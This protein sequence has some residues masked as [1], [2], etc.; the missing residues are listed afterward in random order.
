MS[1]TAPFALLRN[2]PRT[3]LTSTTDDPHVQQNVQSPPFL[4][5]PLNFKASITLTLAPTHTH[6]ERYAYISFSHSHT[7]THTT[8]SLRWLY[9]STQHLRHILRHER[10]GTY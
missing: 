10:R 9:L 3:L 8:T 5:F 4:T 2:H 7:P 1:F 6:T